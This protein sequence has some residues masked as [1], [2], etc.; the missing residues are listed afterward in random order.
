MDKRMMHGG[1]AG[2]GVIWFIGWLFTIGFDNKAKSFQEGPSLE[3]A[4]LRFHFA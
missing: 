4:N 2:A 1:G 3:D